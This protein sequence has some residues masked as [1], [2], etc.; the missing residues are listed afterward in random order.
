MQV[1]IRD[2]ISALRTSC[3]IVFPGNNKRDSPNIPHQYGCPIELGNHNINRHTKMRESIKTPLY[4][5]TQHKG[6]ESMKEC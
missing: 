2:S 3:G 4:G 1:I 6:L 5:T